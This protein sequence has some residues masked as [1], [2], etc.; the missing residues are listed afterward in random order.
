MHPCAC[1]LTE[2][3]LRSCIDGDFGCGWHA[4]VNAYKINLIVQWDI[5]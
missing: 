5:N 1:D 3:L 4:Q 2:M